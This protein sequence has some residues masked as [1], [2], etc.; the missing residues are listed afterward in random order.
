MSIATEL[1]Q[2]QKRRNSILIAIIILFHAVGVYG[3]TSAQ[4]S[5]LFL[6][7][8]PYH[9]LL[10]L[11]V[12]CFSE[13]SIPPKY[14]LFFVLIFLGGYT[15]EWIGIHTGILF[16]DYVY[17]P[18]LGLHLF[19]VPL[20]IGVNWFLL[21]YGAGV[22]MQRTRLKSAILRVLLGAAILVVLDVLIEPVAIRFDYWQWADNYIPLK[23]YVCWFFVA[24]A[25]LW[26]FEKFGFQ[27]QSVVAPV[28][29][30]TQF[31][32]FIALHLI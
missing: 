20:M 10:M 30:V 17:G 24:A 14:L 22:L 8:V 4:W 19:D 23:N 32:F 2:R 15:A 29:L 21:V 12:I 26:L 31:V 16:G 28:L 9:L 18:T 3:L 5:D 6:V 25:M 11:V 13:V 7:I 1:Q 27:K